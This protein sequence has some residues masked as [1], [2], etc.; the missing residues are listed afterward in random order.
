MSLVPEGI[1]S[2]TAC[3]WYYVSKDANY[4]IYY[5][6]VSILS[7]GRFK[8]KVSYP[9]MIDGLSEEINAQN[10]WQNILVWPES[11]IISSFEYTNIIYQ[12]QGSDGNIYIQPVDVR[13]EYD[14]N[15]LYF[16]NS[17]F[18]T[19]NVTGNIPYY[20]I[21]SGLTYWNTIL[22]NQYGFEWETWNWYI[23]VTQALLS[24]NIEPSSV[25]NI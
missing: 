13:I 19:V 4:Y 23:N 22:I 18:L 17:S 8:I 24:I 1:V 6:N 15:A 25:S 16:Q 12:I 11:T 3:D 20:G 2:G 9:G 21:V 7:S 10:W 5:L 14:M